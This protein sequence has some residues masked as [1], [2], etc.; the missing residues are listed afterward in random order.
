MAD[1]FFELSDLVI[2][3]LNKNLVDRYIELDYRK[4]IILE[5]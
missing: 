4:I 5:N 2:L 1:R 3:D